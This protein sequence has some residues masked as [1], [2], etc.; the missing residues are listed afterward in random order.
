MVKAGLLLGLFGGRQSIGEYVRNPLTSLVCSLVVAYYYYC[1][2]GGYRYSWQPSC[3]CSGGSRARKE[4][5]QDMFVHFRILIQL[6]Q[7]TTVLL[8]C[9]THTHTHVHTHTHT[10][11]HKH[12]HT[13][14]HTYT[15]TNLHTHHTDAEGC[16]QCCS[17]WCVCLWQHDHLL[18]SHCH[19]HKGRRSW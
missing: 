17:S 3:S 14:T 12:T 13:H 2:V 1:V 4:P 10:H 7:I 15:H 11:A 19:P 5:G 6:I 8:L 9:T 16:S 18:R